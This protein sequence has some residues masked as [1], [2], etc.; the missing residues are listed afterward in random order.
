MLSIKYLE[1]I[2]SHKCNCV[3]WRDKGVSDF[4]CLIENEIKHLQKLT[5][6]KISDSNNV[7]EWYKNLV[8]QLG[9]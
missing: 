1:K 3:F 4:T 5:P 6:L 8:Q 7:V 9:C 2:K